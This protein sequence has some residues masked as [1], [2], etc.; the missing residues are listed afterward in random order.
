[1][2]IRREQMRVFEAYMKAVFEDRMV[3]HMANDYPRQFAAYTAGGDGDLGARAVVQRA[4]DKSL[5]LGARKESQI[6]QMLEIM[7]ESSPEFEHEAGMEWTR[8]ILTDTSL[9]GGTR[10]L[11][12]HQR[13]RARRSRAPQSQTGKD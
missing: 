10:I 12:V 9:A 13:L 4:V 2:I 1:M 7:L 5:A 11:L 6:Q 3:A 8:E